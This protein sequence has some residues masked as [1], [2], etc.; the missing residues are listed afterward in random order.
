MT[1]NNLYLGV[2]ILIVFIYIYQIQFSKVD[3]ERVF[4][5]E[6]IEPP[7]T[8]DMVLFKA[9]DNIN[10][11]FLGCY[12]G[13]VGIVWVD[14]DDPSKT[15]MCFE[16]AN[17]TNMPLRPHH[18]RRGIF[19]TPLYER[20][21]RYKGKVYIKPLSDPIDLKTQY[22]FKN[23]IQ[24]ALETMKYETRVYYSALKKMFGIE[25]C[26]YLTNCGEIVFLS[27]I[28]LGLLNL[29]RYNENCVHYVNKVCYTK[30]LDNGMAYC[31]PYQ[32]LDHPFAY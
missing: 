14:P 12:Y 10:S 15:P 18:N 6:L 32:L 26:N 25:R 5:D 19:L 8:G 31:A 1:K 29:E 21:R 20:I 2:F 17:T 9:Y 3:C 22:E 28:N 23:F 4:I 27:M 7:K 11:I 30:E 13:H 16:A 24:F